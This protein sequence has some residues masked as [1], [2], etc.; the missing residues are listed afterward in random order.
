[1]ISTVAC[2][3]L[4]QSLRRAWPFLMVASACLL[5]GCGS[6]RNNA[7]CPNLPIANGVLGQRDFTTGTSNAGGIGSGTVSAPFGSITS[8]GQLSYLAD[9]ANNRILGYRTLPAGIGARA[10]FELG[11]GDASGTDFTGQAAGVGPT[12]FSMPSKVS[13]SGDGRLVVADTGNNRVLVWNVLPTGNV[14]PDLVIGQPDFNSFRANQRM[15]TPTA[16]TLNAPTAAVI[17]NGSLIVADRG[18]HRVLIWNAV[19]TAPD[20]P[21]DVELGQASSRTVDGAT[22]SCSTNSGSSGF[23][24]TT[25]LAQGDQAAAT[26]GAAPTLGLSS[27]SDLWSDGYR[28][29][30]SDTGNHRV[31]YWS[32][33]PFANNSLYT[34]VLGQPGPVENT[35]ATSE[36]GLSTPWG[37]YSDGATIYVGD[38]GNNR[39]LLFGGFPVAHGPAA[40]G[41]FGQADFIHGAANDSDQNGTAGSQQGPQ[42]D[43]T[44]T[45]NTLSFPAGVYVSAA[46]QL[47]VADRGNHRLMIYPVTAAVNG[48]VTSNCNDVNP[49]IN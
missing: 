39:V 2:G 9:T 21:A 4:R 34:Y 14:A 31:L 11:Q 28:L 49:R 48:T 30:L 1:M 20:T 7:V 44:P 36:R 16:F 13:I 15:S 10:D 5:A 19:P 45:F 35:A 18:N 42:G 26:E 37:V 17:A 47:Y 46:G 22:V 12:S 3:G 27:P 6:E 40:V 24:F 32:Q 23:C 25:A 41:V 29:L 43:L 8:N 38:A 33:I